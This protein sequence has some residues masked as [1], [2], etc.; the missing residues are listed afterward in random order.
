MGT[1]LTTSAAPGSASGSSAAAPGGGA[2]AEVFEAHEAQLKEIDEKLSAMTV[3]HGNLY[4][5]FLH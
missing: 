4:L 1:S 2:N 5:S 3:C